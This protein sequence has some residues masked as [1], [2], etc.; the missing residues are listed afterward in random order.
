LKKIR[1]NSFKSTLKAKDISAPFL[2]DALSWY[3]KE[4]SADFE[5]GEENKD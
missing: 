1:T 2:C 4:K 5:R 3:L